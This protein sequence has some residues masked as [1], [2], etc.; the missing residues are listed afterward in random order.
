MRDV[1]RSFRV[2]FAKSRMRE[3][4]PYGSVR[5]KPNGLATRPHHSMAG[6]EGGYLSSVITRIAIWFLLPAVARVAVAQTTVTGLVYDS[7]AHAPLAHATVQ[8]VAADDPA[9]FARS[10]AADSIGRFSFSDVPDGRYMIGFF[11][12]RLDTLGIAAP[13]RELRVIRRLPVA[14][15]LAIPGAARLVRA[16][17]GDRAS[18]SASG[19]VMGVVRDARSREPLASVTVAGE[20]VDLILS[21]QGA[22]RRPRRLAATTRDNGWFALCDV[23]AGG[24][25]SLSA[26]RNGDTARV[27]LEVPADGFL[28][29]DVYVAS[30]AGNA[31]VTGVAIAGESN[32]PLA[33]AQITIAG[34]APVR[35]NARG[36]WTVSDAPFG[37]RAL[38]VRAV[39]YYPEHRAIDVLEEMAP[40]RVVLSTMKAV[41]DTVRIRA[42]AGARR[43]LMEFETRRRSS[44]TGTFLTREQVTRA[45]ASRTTDL[46]RMM[47]RIRIRRN[48]SDTT[49][50]QVGEV[51]SWCSP[52]VFVDG[53]PLPK[54]SADE[55]DDV[56][57]PRDIAGVEF[58]PSIVPPQFQDPL[59][60]CGSIVIW[61]R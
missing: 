52:R 46:F 20:W 37:T 35:S 2:T 9:R 17:C 59:E 1:T 18:D 58:Y 23:P 43:E 49:S 7:A 32:A 30:G 22:V 39:G 28:H 56:V 12:P 29:R 16:I 31:R 27:D 48:I 13:V 60:S 33:N 44:G 38:D 26:S 40:Q 53:H 6:P 3:S 4:R 55:L 51:N 11:H 5:A 45:N 14:I 34:A 54:M 47:P 50:L 24:T 10:S 15:D 61:R 8:L 42:A 36:E 19:V 41:L 21:A 25:V 57:D